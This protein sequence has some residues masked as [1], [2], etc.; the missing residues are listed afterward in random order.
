M[1]TTTTP[2][3][4]A[5]AKDGKAVYQGYDG[6][7]A[8]TFCR[9]MDGKELDVVI[10]K[11]TKK[12]TRKQREYYWPGIVKPIADHIGEAGKAG[13]NRVHEGLKDKFLR[14]ADPVFGFRVRSTEELSTTEKEE[15][16]A[17][18]RQW[19]AEFLGLY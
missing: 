13:E 17:N 11:H 14:V 15:Y 16:H 5:I 12:A 6:K 18:C 19:A 7:R 4:R 8:E 10:R 3:L 2:I 9:F 1:P